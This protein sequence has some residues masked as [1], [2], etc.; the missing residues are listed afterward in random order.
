MVKVLI[1]TKVNDINDTP[2]ID[3]IPEAP[4]GCIFFHVN[5]QMT[6]KRNRYNTER[7]FAMSTP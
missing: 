6:C 1:G 2:Y 7:T 4:L 5:G 3:E